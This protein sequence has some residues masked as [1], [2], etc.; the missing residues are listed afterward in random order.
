M[1]LKK[2]SS[3]KNKSGRN[4]RKKLKVL[5][6]D[7]DEDGGPQGQ[8][9]Y[10]WNIFLDGINY[11]VGDM[12]YLARDYVDLDK[13]D[14]Y[15]VKDNADISRI[16]QL[17]RDSTDKPW[18]NINHFYIPESIHRPLHQKF[19]RN[20]VFSIKEMG[21]ANLDA[22]MGFCAVL[23][24]TTYRT[25]DIRCINSEHIYVMEAEYNPSQKRQSKIKWSSEDYCYCHLPFAF[26]KFF[27]VQR[28]LKKDYKPPFS[29]D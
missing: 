6:E 21:F 8:R 29:L 15:N 14:K 24:P 12:V 25:G 26:K 10:Y 16:H 5:H 19:F 20:E 1:E 11:K 4:P 13:K 9:A 2:S 23:K 3:R 17:F 27:N 7:E 28:P 22:I 18:M